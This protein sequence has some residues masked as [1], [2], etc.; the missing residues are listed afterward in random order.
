[1]Q[2]EGTGKSYLLT[3]VYLWC[4][5]KK[6]KVRAGAPTGIAAANIEEPY[7]DIR[8]VTLHNMSSLTRIVRR[9]STFRTWSSSRLLHFTRWTFC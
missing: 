9:S 2:Y 5:V 8:A 4:L 6:I 3:S 7:T 1:M